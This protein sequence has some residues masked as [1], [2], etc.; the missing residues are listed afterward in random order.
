MVAELLNVNEVED[1]SLS[2]NTYLFVDLETGGLAPERHSILQLAAVLTDHDLKVQSHFMTYIRPHPDLAV[3]AEALAINQLRVED[4]ITAPDEASVAQAL[5]K[6]AHL[7][8]GKPRFAGF[9]CKFDLQFLTE[10]WRRQGDIAPPYRVP[11]L[12]VLDV[13]RLK[14]EFDDQLTN[15][16]L[17]TIAEHLGID[18]AGAHDAAYDLLI[19][20]EVAKR[21]KAMP[22][23]DGAVVLETA[24]FS[25]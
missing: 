14:P 23:R 17:A 6:F 2:S 21:L 8:L 19:T 12:D 25:Q 4:L 7:A 22:G 5:S 1:Q 11:W 15:L 16:K 10:L 3:T 18:C 9:N 20:I 13:A 24:R